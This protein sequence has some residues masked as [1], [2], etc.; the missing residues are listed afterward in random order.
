MSGFKQ[1][2]K[3]MVYPI[4]ATRS[5]GAYLWDLD[6]NRWVD[7]TMGFGVALLGHS[8]A[9]ITEA[10]KQQLELG[11]EIGPQSP[12]AGKLAKATPNSR[13]WTTLRIKPFMRTRDTRASASRG[14]PGRTLW[15][16]GMNAG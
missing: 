7:V 9:F 2:W 12:I 3:E 14:G 13:L 4:V 6:D 11:V 16:V 15:R 1:N 5:A 8:P 10:V